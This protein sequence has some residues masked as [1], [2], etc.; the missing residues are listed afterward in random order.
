MTIDIPRPSPKGKKVSLFVT[1]IVDMIYPNTGM[2]AVEVLERLGLTVDFPTD[3]TCCGQMGF[4]AGYRA[5]A[6]TVAKQFMRAFRDSEVI[7]APSGSCVSMV[8]HFYPELFAD[9]PDWR[10]E[11]ERIVG[12]TWELTEFLVDGLGVTDMGIQL[13]QPLTVALHDACHGLRMLELGTQPRA[14]LEHVGNLQIVDLPGANQCCGFGGLF[15]VK[16]P[17]VSGAMLGD[18]IKNIDAVA[19]DVIVTG[20]ASCLTQI[21]GGLS[22]NRSARRVVHIAEV[23]AGRVSHDSHASTHE[24]R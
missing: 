9:D 8:R 13:E 20:D 11:M 19:A 1:C 3:Q 17:E 6:K 2:A 18:K 10:A 5:D 12:N 7:V 22:R 16:M 21:N 4:N 23:L 14:L 24:H 15:A